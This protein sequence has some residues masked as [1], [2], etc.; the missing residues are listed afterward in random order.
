MNSKILI[1]AVDPEECRIAKIKDKHLIEFQ[2][3]NTAREITKGNIYKGVVVRVEPSLQAVFV[4]YGVGRHGFLQ[5]HE[6]HS[7]YFQDNRDGKDSIEHIVKPNQELLVQITK[8]PVMKKGAMLTTFLSL[9]GRHMV[10]MPGSKNRGIS[11]K[12]EDE[13]ERNRIKKLIDKLKVPLEF[14][15]IIRTAGDKCNIAVLLKDMRNLMLVWENIKRL[16][17]ELE[18]P[19]LL[20]QESH[21]AIRAIRDHLTDDVTE[22]LID[23]DAL[24][25]EVKEFTNMVSPK[26]SRLVKLYADHEPLFT[27]FKIEDQ[28]ASVYKN[29]VPLK[30]GGSIVI[31]QTEA[32]VAIDVNSG[33]ATKEASVEDTAYKINIEAAEMIALQ[34]RLRDLGGLI[35]IDFIDMKENRHKNTVEK[36]LRD[37]LKLDKARTKVGKISKFGLLEMSR[38][39]ISPPID[40][41]TYMKCLHCKGRGLIPSAETEALC[42][43]RKLRMSSVKKETESIKVTLPINVAEYLLNR[44]RKEILDLES[45]LNISIQIEGDTTM[46][47]GEVKIH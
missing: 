34:L 4:D 28:I 46:M 9:P 23:N 17:M 10:L 39:R 22:I 42:L 18:Q 38:Q 30:S 29:R 40:Y 35:V 14:G 13:K 6:I 1:N 47:P 2:I 37:S 27:K 33:K 20:Y 36:A 41:G 45:R 21:A 19:G 12:I 5:K 11:R 3:E 26:H 24:C 16:G 32:L 7:E 31:D 25:N 8:D 15:I 43:L 44:K